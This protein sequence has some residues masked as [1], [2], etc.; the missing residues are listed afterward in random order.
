MPRKRGKVRSGQ[1]I[2]LAVTLLMMILIMAGSLTGFYFYMQY[3]I[4]G[5]TREGF[6]PDDL[7]VPINEERY[8]ETDDRPVFITH[9]STPS[10]KCKLFWPVNASTEMLDG[11]TGIGAVLNISLENTGTSEIYVENVH[12]TSRWGAE[13]SG[14][15]GKYVKIGQ[16]RYLRH[17][18][19]PIPDPAPSISN[20]SYTVSIDVLIENGMTWVRK[21]KMSFDPSTVSIIDPAPYSG[22]PSIK[23]NNAYYYDKINDLVKQDVDATR[24]FVENSTLGQG[25]YTI[26][27]VVDIFEFVIENLVYIPDPDTG[28]N[29]WIS[30]MTCLAQGGG[31]CEDYSILFASLITAVGGSARVIITNGHAFNAVYIGEDTS[32]LSS[33]EDRFGIEI[34]FQIFEDDLGKWLIIEPQSYL[35]FGWFP[36]D[37][38]PTDTSDEMMYLY[39]SNGLGWEFVDSN[40]IYMVDIY[41]M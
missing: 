30:P 14:E 7:L 36:L 18:L 39:G 9:G 17:I 24:S 16:E 19:L 21:Q 15:V 1:V 12:V 8:L 11:Y 6:S 4:D 38:A 41:L 33:I 3:L 13:A 35:V 29:Q 5:Q 37:V 20:R 26:Q 25:D 2:K 40:E 34:P 27:K 10:F 22:P 32:S 31:D 23:V 28:K